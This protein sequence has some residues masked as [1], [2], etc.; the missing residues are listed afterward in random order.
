MM[1]GGAAKANLLIL[2]AAKKGDAGALIIRG[3]KLG[4]FFAALGM[5]EFLGVSG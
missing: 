1:V 5:T 2:S 3:H 4:R